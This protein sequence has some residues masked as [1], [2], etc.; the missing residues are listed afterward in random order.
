[1]LGF[2]F[3]AR[4]SRESE[5]PQNPVWST[6][7]LRRDDMTIKH[8]IGTVH[9]RTV[10]RTFQNRGTRWPLMAVILIRSVEEPL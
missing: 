1:M 2:L 9:R 5:P 4:F 10:A 3:M 8:F 6:S 7:H